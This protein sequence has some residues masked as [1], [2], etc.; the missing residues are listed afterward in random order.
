M[1]GS[2]GSV[3]ELEMFDQT[4]IIKTIEIKDKERR[5]KVISSAIKE[6]CCLKIA[7]ALGFAPKVDN[8]LGFDM[9]IFDNCVQFAM[10]KTPRIDNFTEESA[11][12]LQ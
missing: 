8:Y 4:I 5:I 6:Y 3:S 10:E 9:I 7:S 11:Q 12:Q 2:F 1:S